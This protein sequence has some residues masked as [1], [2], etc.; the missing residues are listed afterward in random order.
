MKGIEE[1]EQFGWELIDE[2]CGFANL[3]RQVG[4]APYEKKSNFQ[5]AK[6]R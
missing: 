5:R 6:K 1:K 2:S 4:R 3:W